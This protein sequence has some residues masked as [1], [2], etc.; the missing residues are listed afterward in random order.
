M[1]KKNGVDKKRK[2]LIAG[3]EPQDELKFLEKKFKKEENK[4]MLKKA[5]EEDDEYDDEQLTPEDPRYKQELENKEIEEGIKEGFITDE[6]AE[7]VYDAE[8]A[9]E[10]VDEDE[11]TSAEEGFVRGYEAEEETHFAKKKK[12][13]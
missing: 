3:L 1:A 13:K 6:K 8:E 5:K 11:I 2:K 7:E 12:K 4:P 9:E 10:L